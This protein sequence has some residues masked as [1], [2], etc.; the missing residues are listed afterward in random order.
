[1][2]NIP[3]KIWAT[4]NGGISKQLL[5]QFNLAQM[6]LQQGLILIGEGNPGGHLKFGS[7]QPSLFLHVLHG[8]VFT[9]PH[10]QPNLKS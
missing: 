2:W 8:N 3:A 5:I 9:C 6:F 10:F 1:M 4:N 7:A